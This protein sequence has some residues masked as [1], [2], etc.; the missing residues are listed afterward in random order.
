MTHV[1]T[2]VE[3]YYRITGV[4]GYNVYVGE[5]V[6]PD[7]DAAPT[8][9]APALPIEL[10]VVP[11]VSGTKAINVVVRALNKFGL[12]SQNQVPT[13]FVIDHNGS[14]VPPPLDSPTSLGAYLRDDGRLKVV[15]S[16][17]A[18]PVASYPAD[19]WLIWILQDEPTGT[20]SAGYP[21]AQPTAT[22]AASA[23]LSYITLTPMAA[24]HTFM[25]AVALARSVDGALSPPLI[26]QVIVPSPPARPE[27]V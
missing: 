10:D 8:R 14:R 2:S 23:G 21:D 26:T 7:F 15:A 3:S 20:A 16:Y 1:N 22:V 13:T 9:F 25:V 24:G 4:P 11:P 27:S 19:R 6:L 17:P 18:Y 12:E 5:D